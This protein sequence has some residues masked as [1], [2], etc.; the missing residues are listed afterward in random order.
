MWVWQS[1]WG[2]EGFA[3][4]RAVPV[5]LHCTLVILCLCPVA[6]LNP[7]IPLGLGTL[8]EP[9]AATGD[10]SEGSGLVQASSTTD[11]VLL[12]TGKVM[13]EAAME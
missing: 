11:T 8:W 12:A 4:P 7:S 2:Q 6:A 5:L 13:D 10:S 9:P 1:C 3:A